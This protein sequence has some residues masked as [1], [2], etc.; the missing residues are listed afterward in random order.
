MR[1]RL[2]VGRLG[3]EKFGLF[4][5]VQLTRGPGFEPYRGP[6]VTPAVSRIT[7]MENGRRRHAAWVPVPTACVRCGW[8]GEKGPGRYLISHYCVQTCRVTI[9][10]LSHSRPRA[11]PPF[12]QD[13]NETH[14]V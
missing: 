11:H 2:P 1:G 9:S 7:A 3:C 13:N 8:G 10:S 4:H 12:R 14:Q 6:S 5:H